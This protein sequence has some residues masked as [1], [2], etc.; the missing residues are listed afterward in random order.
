MTPVFE[1]AAF[2]LK[3]GATSG[4]IET[5]FGFH[6]IKVID[7]RG[8]RTAPLAEVKDQI[9]QFLT[10]QQREQKLEAFVGQIKAK[11]KIQILV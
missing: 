2:T 9:Q 7:K 11:G 10:Q 3:K 1:Q 5:P 4:V 8:P 6:I